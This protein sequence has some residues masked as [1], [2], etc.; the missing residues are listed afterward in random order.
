VELPVTAR[1]SLFSFGLETDIPI[2]SVTDTALTGA[3]IPVGIS[4]SMLD[5]YNL[6]FSGSSP[7]F[8]RIDELILLGQTV[9]M[10]FGAS[11]DGTITLID[12]DF[13]GF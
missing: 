1:F 12:D 9:R 10:T 8:P 3:S 13:P 6:Q 7:M 11:I 2:F 4:R 5:F